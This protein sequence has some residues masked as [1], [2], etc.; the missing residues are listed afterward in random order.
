MGTRVRVRMRMHHVVGV[1]VEDENMVKA[2]KQMIA[3][4]VVPHGAR[5]FP[6]RRHHRRP[7]GCTLRGALVRHPHAVASVCAHAYLYALP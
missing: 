2:D 1:V 3:Q 7:H 5:G 4:E 6:H